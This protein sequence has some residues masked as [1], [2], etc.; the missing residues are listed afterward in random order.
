M[1]PFWPARPRF[2]WIT[3]PIRVHGP[4]RIPHYK[5]D[6]VAVYTNTGPA[7]SMRSIGGPQSIWPLESQMDIIAERL[8]MDPVELRIKN[9][10]KRGE[11]LRAGVK[12]MDADLAMGL[13]KAATQIGWNQGSKNSPKKL[14]VAV[15]VSDSEA[16]PV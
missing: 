11:P 7:G 9:L 16:S 1:G 3:A 12:P 4:Y 6:V 13:K 2:F 8:G 10:A 14:G 5:I 15:G